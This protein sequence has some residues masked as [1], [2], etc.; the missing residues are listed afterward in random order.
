VLI[1]Y[2]LSGIALFVAVFQWVGGPLDQAGEMTV[3]IEGQRTAVVEALDEAVSTIDATTDGIR[4]MDTSLVQA[5]QATDRAA[6][7][8]LNM[9]ATMYALRDQMGVAVFGVQ[10]LI[11]LAPGFEQTGQQMELLSADVGA[12]GQALGANREDVETVADSMVQMRSSVEQL[13]TAVREGPRLE[14]TSDTLAGIRL[15]VFALVAW[16]VSLAVGC[17]IAGVGCWW[18]ARRA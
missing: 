6:Q 18:L 4:N 3:S 7:L 12:I 1:L 9:A 11:G 15:G 13:A 16:L 10:P 14:A 5:A 17:L 8:S 2:G